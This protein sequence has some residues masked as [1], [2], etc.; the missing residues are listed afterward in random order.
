MKRTSILSL[1][2][3]AAIG[4][5]SGSFLDAALAASGN[6]IFLPQ[7]TLGLALLAIAV[8]VVVLAL[9][10]RRLT[11]GR[12]TQP[13]DPLYSTRVLVLAK[14]S[15]LTGSLIFGFGLGVLFY[16]LSRSFE[17]GVGSVL[18]GVFT[19]LGAAA[20]LLGG[21]IAEQMCTIPPADRDRNNSDRDQSERENDDRDH[22]DQAVSG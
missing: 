11:R 4:G 7:L 19:A 9:P 2:L 13:I 22:G 16:L 21:L 6:P 20:L 12:L 1:V 14:A 8:M 15:A 5:I 3:L 10:I 18:S 17:P